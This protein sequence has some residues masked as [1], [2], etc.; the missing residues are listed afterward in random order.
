[1]TRDLGLLLARGTIGASLMAHGAQKAFGSFGGPGP[2]GTAGFMESLRFTPGKRFATIAAAGELGGGALLTL[3]LGGPLAA[4][5]IVATMTVAAVS[6]HAKNGF[7]AQDN[8][9]E[10]PAIYSAAAAALAM[11]GPGE[12]SLDSALGIDLRDERLAWLAV[13]V[14]IAA[15]TI[16]LAQRQPAP[17]PADA[18]AGSTTPGA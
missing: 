10:L 9:F 7:F 6:V 8:G 1:M 11:S 13:M 12:L 14:G 5:A 16:A 2:A 3:G 17:P 4:T 15:G 18:V